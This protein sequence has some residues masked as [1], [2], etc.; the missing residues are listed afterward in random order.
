MEGLTS[1]GC[2]HSP[3]PYALKHNPFAYYG[4]SCPDNVVSLDTLDADLAHDTPRFVWITP[5]L[6]HDGHDCALAESGPWLE[7][8]VA[9]IVASSAWRDGG[10]LFI[11]W[12]E[13]DGRSSIVPLIVATRDLA[14]RRVDASYDHYSLLAAIEDAFGLPRLGAAR[15][16]RP[17]TDLLPAS[18]R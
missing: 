15:D 5:G 3:Y 6:C 18:T 4:G 13:G 16:A 1:A 2:M 14:G 7:S 17:L 12:D 11:V 10:A 8:L 9:K